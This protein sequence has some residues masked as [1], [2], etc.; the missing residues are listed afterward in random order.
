MSVRDYQP[1]AD[2]HATACRP[3]SHN[4]RRRAG[5]DSLRTAFENSPNGVPIPV[6]PPKH[7]TCNLQLRT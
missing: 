6:S 7:V 1:V 5:D 2:H 4:G 3:N